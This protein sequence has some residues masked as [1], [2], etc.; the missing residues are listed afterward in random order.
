M[1]SIAEPFQR[2][3]VHLLLAVLLHLAVGLVIYAIV[4]TGVHRPQPVMLEGLPIVFGKMI[5]PGEQEGDAPKTLAKSNPIQ[6]QEA[7]P[8]AAAQAARTPVLEQQK[9]V[10]AAEA[11][12]V[13]KPAATMAQ[14]Q[15]T[16]TPDVRPAQPVV[17]QSEARPPGQV[18]LNSPQGQQ[19]VAANV[20]TLRLKPDPEEA[21]REPP[22]PEA[23]VQ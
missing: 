18:A 2:G 16:V 7:K 11:Q 6:A 10:T 9:P 13:T 20:P 14:A 17:A 8:E 3:E 23:N 15:K 22:P 5:S 19:A 1:S 21:K 4:A 12:P